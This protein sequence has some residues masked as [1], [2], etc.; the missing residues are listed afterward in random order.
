MLKR[1]GM[2][3]VIHKGTSVEHTDMAGILKD[4]LENPPSIRPI[5][6]GEYFKVSELQEAYLKWADYHARHGL[7][8]QAW[9]NL[10]TILGIT[11]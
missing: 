10:K 7:N 6:D 11:R 3:K 4:A 9:E 1:Y 5:E 8:A 2:V